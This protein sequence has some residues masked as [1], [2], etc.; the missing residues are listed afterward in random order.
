MF[1]IQFYRKFLTIVEVCLIF[2][3]CQ[4]HYLII[5]NL[6]KFFKI[7]LILY[8]FAEIIL[9]KYKFKDGYYYFL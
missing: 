6:S 7:Y 9:K 8:K 2:F 1:N 4:N 3:L 5:F